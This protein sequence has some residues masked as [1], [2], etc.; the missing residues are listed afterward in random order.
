MNDPYKIA[1][2]LWVLIFV[3]VEGMALRNKR[4][5]DTLSENMRILFGTER[6]PRG[7]SRF[8]KLRRL[9]LLAGLAWFTVHILT[10]GWI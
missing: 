10:P 1:W 8:V 5:E 7:S 9:V 2:V 3:V 6:K 4:K